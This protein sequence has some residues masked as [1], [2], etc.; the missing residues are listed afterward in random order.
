MSHPANIT[1]TLGAQL[2]DEQIAHFNTYGFVHFKNFISRETVAELVAASKDI[3]R[4][5]LNERREK[6]NGIPI[7]YGRDLDG[8][9]IVQR[10]AFTNQFHQR[11]A[12]FLKD[13]RF[14]VLFPLVGREGA[15]VG[16][17]EKDGL[18]L[19]HYVNSEGSSHSRLGWHTDGLRDLFLGKRQIFPMLN[20]GVHLNDLGLEHGG[21][22]LI[23]GTHT[24]GIW[25]MI[26]GKRYFFD[27][28][29][30]PRE[31]AVI[32]EAG[33]LTVHD[34]RLWHRVQQSSVIGEAS[35]R[36]VFYVPIVAGPY[37][38]KSEASPTPFYHRL[39]SKFGWNPKVSEA[40]V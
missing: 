39:A 28:K 30:D 7:K 29:P 26:F 25:K 3:E 8:K 18:V 10:F 6:V 21:L 32:P 15:R 1:F 23:P 31:I 22:R 5:W 37:E 13:P 16:G 9:P 4:Q 34:G 11:L 36:R 24:Q 27:H 33:D 20:V 14:T 38:P 35:R 2:T 17:D 12:E 19:N 40:T